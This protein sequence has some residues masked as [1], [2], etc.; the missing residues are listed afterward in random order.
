M[1]KLL[2]LDS[3]GTLLSV[4]AEECT[5]NTVGS[6]ILLWDAIQESGVN[7]VN[8]K[9]IGVRDTNF[10]HILA[11]HACKFHRWPVIQ[12]DSRYQFCDIRTVQLWN[13]VPLLVSII[14]C[15]WFSSISGKIKKYICNLCARLSSYNPWMFLNLMCFLLYKTWLCWQTAG[16]F[17]AEGRHQSTVVGWP[18]HGQESTAEVCGELLSD[19]CKYMSA[20]SLFHGWV[21]TGVTRKYAKHK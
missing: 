19:W 1:K 9:T 7:G 5:L 10:D 14:N 11:F 8:I 12:F 4:E 6:L 18:R 16:R 17:D 20:L 15:L 21:S 13:E 2:L 3:S